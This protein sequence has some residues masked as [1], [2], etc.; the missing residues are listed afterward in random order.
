VPLSSKQTNKQ[1]CAH[2]LILWYVFWVRLTFLIL[3]IALF[4]CIHCKYVLSVCVQVY[5]GLDIVTNKVTPEERSMC[6]H[7]MIDFVSPLKSNYTVTDFKNASLPLVSLHAIHC[8]KVLYFVL[9]SKVTC[10]SHNG[11]TLFL[12]LS[13][14]NLTLNQITSWPN[15]RNYSISC[16]CNFSIIILSPFKSSPMNA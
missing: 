7:H 3:F 15:H 1:I 5:Q 9:P 11:K 12:M 4:P 8:W 10:S 13:N 16:N 14:C 2:L 6:P